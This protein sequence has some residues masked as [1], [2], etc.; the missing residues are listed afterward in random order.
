MN[1]IC[2]LL[3]SITISS[4]GCCSKQR[5]EPPYPSNV[6]GWN[7]YKE[8][9]VR[10]LGS[11]VL[12]KDEITD[13]GQVQVQ[14]IELIP[15]EPCVD[16][17]TLA[18]HPKVKLRFVRSSDQALL[19]TATYAENEGATLSRD[20]GNVLSEFGILGIGIRAINLKDGWVFLEFSG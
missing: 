2:L 16:A 11:F 3:V 1:T 15:G 12:R 4:S 8:M 20:C 6:S 17:G 18:S 19:C 14:V 10:M 7:E 5:T 13:N 9:G